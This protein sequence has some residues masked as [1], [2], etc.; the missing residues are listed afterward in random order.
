MRSAG[1]YRLTYPNTSPPCL[2]NVAT[3]AREKLGEGGNGI[4]G[5]RGMKITGKQTR[6][7]KDRES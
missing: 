2:K 5:V 6:R 4:G 3:K 7:E 1:G